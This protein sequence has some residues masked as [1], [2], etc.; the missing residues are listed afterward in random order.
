MLYVDER[1]CGL[2]RTKVSDKKT[3]MVDKIEGLNVG[4]Y[5]AQDVLVRL[6]HHLTC[7]C[8]H[9]LLITPTASNGSTNSTRTWHLMQGT[10]TMIPE[11]ER[12]G[13]MYSRSKNCPNVLPFWND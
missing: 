3:I 1:C 12:P 4:K 8:C 13:Y 10:T 11:V 6:H 2:N 7:I 9:R 5:E